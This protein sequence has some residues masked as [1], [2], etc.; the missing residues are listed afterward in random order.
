LLFPSGLSAIANVNLA[1]LKTGDEALLP[2]N[3]YGPNRELFDM[4][5]INFG[6]T[7]R[8]YDPMQPDA[9]EFKPNT[10]LM[11]LEAPGSVTM[12]VPDLPALAARARAAGVTTAVD[13]TYAAG[14]AFRPFDHGIDI[15]VQAL[16]KFQSGAGDVLMGNNTCTDEALHHQLKLA[17][18][19]TGVGVGGDDVYLVARSL[20]TLQLRFN[21]SDRAGRE[22]ASWLAGQT[23]ISRVLHPALPSC[24]G[25]D[26][27]QRT[28]TGAAGLF[29]VVIDERFSREQVDAFVDGLQLFKIGY[30]WAG[31][32]SL[33]VPYDIK[34]MRPNTGAAWRGH[35]VRFWVGLEDTRDLI[36]DL[37]ASLA[38]N[39]PG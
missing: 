35:L 15:S 11:W 32:M 20:P 21:A 9:V 28:F 14:I 19:R 23:Q 6:I 37:Q 36:A 38:A 18:M 31:P 17:R 13:N 34:A 7:H 12:E 4:L 16:T 33:V 25:H 1:L 39:L 5:L 10:R 24:P 8:L 3:S 29:S 30:S 26:N 22:L 27:W 2:E